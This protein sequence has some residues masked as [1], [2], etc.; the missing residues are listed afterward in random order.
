MKIFYCLNFSAKIRFFV[1]VLIERNVDMSN[2]LNFSDVYRGVNYTGSL[3]IFTGT[4]E[5]VP[6]N[7]AS[8]PV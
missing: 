4:P 1:K 5:W 6:V 2:G 3:A 7:I 8:D